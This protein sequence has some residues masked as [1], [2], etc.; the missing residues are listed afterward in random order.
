MFDMK[1]KQPELLPVAGVRDAESS[2]LM[3][4]STSPSHQRLGLPGQNI[5]N[6]IH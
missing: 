2:P 4:G 6:T 1:R 3:R 5:R